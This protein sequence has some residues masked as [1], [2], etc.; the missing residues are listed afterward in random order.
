MTASNPNWIEFGYISLGKPYSISQ[1]KIN[2]ND[3]SKFITDSSFGDVSKQVTT[4]LK[5]LSKYNGRYTLYEDERLSQDE[6][7]LGVY[8]GKWHVVLSNKDLES[9][10]SNFVEKLLV[11]KPF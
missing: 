2:I 10:I 1:I 8:D 5:D 11:Q 3:P 4:F 7:I 6:F 9:E